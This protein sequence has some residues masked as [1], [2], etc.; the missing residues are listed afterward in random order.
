MPAARPTDD[1]A[2]SSGGLVCPR[3]GGRVE[4]ALQPPPSDYP[5]VAELRERAL[6]ALSGLSLD[7][8]LA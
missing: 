3:C 2:G 5:P 6:A 4:D 7:A 1:P 8:P